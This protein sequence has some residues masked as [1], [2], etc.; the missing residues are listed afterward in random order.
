MID[1]ASSFTAG[2]GMIV[3]VAGERTVTVAKPSAAERLARLARLAV[4]DADAVESVRR[5][6]EDILA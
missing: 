2:A 1:P 6:L 3:N 4:T 5:A